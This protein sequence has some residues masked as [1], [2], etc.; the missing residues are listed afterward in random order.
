MYLSNTPLVEFP[1]TPTVARM[2]ELPP[3]R[4]GTKKT[5]DLM[6]QVV[7]DSLKDP[8]QKIRETALSIVRGLAPRRSFA[9]VAALQHYVRDNIRYVHDPVPFELLQT[10]QKT[11]EYRAGDCDDKSMLLA[12]LLMATGHPAR[13]VSLGFKGG[14]LSHVLVDTRIRDKWVPLETI[15]EDA[16]PGW[17]P[18]GITSRYIR[19]L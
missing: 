6:R 1:R 2:G 17:M 19:P 8:S 9:E 14:P 7:L 4:A 12:A 3:G 5:L 11:L 13:F 16:E 10:P 18:S 15:V